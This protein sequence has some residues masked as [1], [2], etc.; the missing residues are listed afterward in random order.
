MKTET[1]T[2][3]AALRILARDIDS[4]DGIANSCIEEAANRLEELEH[5][6]IITQFDLEQ[7]ETELDALRSQ[8]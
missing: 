2:L 4:E 8:M 3:V 1:K 6:L 5:Q 7:L